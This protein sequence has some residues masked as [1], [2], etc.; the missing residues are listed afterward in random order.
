MEILQ[1]VKQSAH[2]YTNPDVQMGYGIPDFELAYANLSG[3]R[4][5]RY[6]NILKQN[7]I[8]AYPIPFQD[9]ITVLI[10]VPENGNAT[11]QLL[12]LTGR[13]LQSYSSN[14]VKDSYLRLQPFSHLSSLPRGVY[15]IRYTDG[16]NT[17]TIQ[18]MK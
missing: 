3:L 11:L 2:L 10:K 14:V 8:K 1:A 6:G 13:I 17:E 12:D 9:N 4:E 5:E 18:V 7:W 16:N 15:F